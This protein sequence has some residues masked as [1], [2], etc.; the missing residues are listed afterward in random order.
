[1]PRTLIEKRMAIDLEQEIFAAEAYHLGIPLLILCLPCST[2]SPE[3]VP[4]FD[5]PDRRPAGKWGTC[6]H[7][8]QVDRINRY[9]WWVQGAVLCKADSSAYAR[10]APLLCRNFRDLTS[11]DSVRSGGHPREELEPPQLDLGAAVLQQPVRGLEGLTALAVA[12]SNQEPLQ[13]NADEPL[14]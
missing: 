5:F 2:C 9:F 11:L 14:Q 4:F 1:M 6:C 8:R 3:R 10:L 13:V 12:A 7:R